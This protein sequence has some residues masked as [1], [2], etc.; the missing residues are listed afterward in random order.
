VL[1]KQTDQISM[2]E[3]NQY[4]FVSYAKEDLERVLPLVEA[5][6]REF[7][8]RAL[9]LSVWMDVSNLV[10]GEKW[11]VAISAALEASVGFLLFL[12]P[13]SIRSDWVQREVKL[14][15]TA[16]D[17]LIIPILLHEPLDVPPPL[18]RFQWLR[19]IGRPSPEDTFRA[20]R[21][22]GEATE[23][24]LR[25]TP[26]PSPPVTKAEAPV[27]AA[28][29][30]REVRS[31]GEGLAPRGTPKTVF[32]VHGHDADALTQLE[33]FLN[34]VD[35][36]SIVLS[37]QDESAQSLFQKFMAVGGRAGFAIV[38]MGADDYGASRRQ[39]DASGVG[40]RALQFRARQN[41]VLELGFFYG[42]LGW[43]N[44]FVVYKRPD[45][46]FPNFER[47][48]DLEGVVFDSMEDATWRTK[49]ARRLSAAGFELRRP[50]D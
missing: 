14:A 40:D 44:V 3:N 19:F 6:R 45:R 7:A 5:V 39:Y 47:P 27:I 36:E 2:A 29:I 15:A 46:V 48:S 37:R 17:R 26:K 20:A 16:S 30:A 25:A 10:P 41:V 28:D 12:S 11:N 4:L 1:Q 23:R 38:I 21:E 33:E 49:L 22:I 8:S 43:E 34:S 24:Y 13:R 18:T 50:T 31:S 42:K 32:V 9:P 35:I